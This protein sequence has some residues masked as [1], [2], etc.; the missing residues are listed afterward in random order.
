M[1][2]DT[3]QIPPGQAIQLFWNVTFRGWRHRVWA[4]ITR[5]STRLLDLDETLKSGEITGSRYAGLKPV[6]IKDIHGTQGKADV[7]D[8]AFFPKRTIT[9]SRW[10][11]IAKAKLYGK[12]LPPVDLILVDGVYYVRD[13]HHRISVSRTMGQDFVDAEITII[14]MRRNAL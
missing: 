5:R 2:P 4:R 8:D 12:E 10:L 13:G 9:R 14:Q 1:S 3:R 7:F 11:S 6:E